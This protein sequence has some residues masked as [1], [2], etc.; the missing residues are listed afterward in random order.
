MRES[1]SWKKYYFSETQVL[2]THLPLCMVYCIEIEIV[3]IVTGYG[4]VEHI[5]AAHNAAYILQLTK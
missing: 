5:H 4:N 2:M 1:I 3:G